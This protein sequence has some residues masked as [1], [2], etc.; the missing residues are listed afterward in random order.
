MNNRTLQSFLALAPVI[1]GTIVFIVF[2]ASIMDN[3]IELSNMEEPPS[4]P[5]EFPEGFLRNMMYSV[6]G[7]MICGLISLIG[8]VYFV[9][10]SAKNPNLAGNTMRVVWIILIIVLSPIGAT[11]YWLAEIALKTP[12][13]VITDAPQY[14]RD[15]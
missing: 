8:L 10:H 11:I 15:N 12:K 6:A 5:S 9:I 7:F 14:E 4:D 13:P 2:F 3:V 1:L